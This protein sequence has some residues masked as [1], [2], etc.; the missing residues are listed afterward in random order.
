[1]DKKI[2][3]ENKKIGQGEPLFITA[4]IGV[5]HN[6]SLKTAKKMIDAAKKCG[7]DAV[8]FQT[9]RT[10]EFMDD[11]NIKYSY[12]YKNK[13]V[14][15]N[16]FDMFKRLELPFAWHKEL[17]GYARKK[18]LVPLSSAADAESVK[19]LV[20]LKANCIK[21]ASDDLTN[22]PL[23]QEAAKTCL[24]II[25]ST[26]MA[27]EKEIA[28]AL[29]CIKKFNNKIIL[30]HCVSIY[31]TPERHANILRI[32]SLQEEFKVLVGFSDHTQG[33]AAAVGACALGA[34]FI[35]K[36]FTLNHNMR[37]PDH[38]FS[39]DPKQMKEYV[40][41]IRNM[42]KIKG[43][44]KIMPSQEELKS[45]RFCRRSV[46]AARDIPK[47]SVVKKSDICLKRPGTG[48]SYSKL[49]LVLGKKTKINIIKGKQIKLNNLVK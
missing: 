35:E 7:V 13:T 23:L 48:L 25:L 1:M 20:K 47:G 8:K 39:A 5:N 15:E 12:K 40:E 14:L 30:L 34:V 49:N 11:T 21:I 37:G 45:L 41:K 2:I 42:E 32:K 26:G 17:F 18:G 46:T 43:D 6:G 24:P 28:C 22:I 33:S 31:P 10:E 16:M 27:D 36:H 38:K 44:G 3:L 19:L 29:R 9:F 4:E